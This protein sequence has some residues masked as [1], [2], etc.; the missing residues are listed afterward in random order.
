MEHCDGAI[1]LI[2]G[3]GKFCCPVK[4]EMRSSPL[5]EGLDCGLFIPV[6]LLGLVEG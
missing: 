5:G 3:T 4:A 2:L 1:G 6:K